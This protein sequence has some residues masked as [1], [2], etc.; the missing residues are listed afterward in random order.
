M[1]Q[2]PQLRLEAIQRLERPVSAEPRYSD[3]MRRGK[4]TAAEIQARR[5]QAAA[6][7]RERFK[8]PA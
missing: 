1:K 4:E 8:V 7:L 5:R 6:D 3:A 2:K